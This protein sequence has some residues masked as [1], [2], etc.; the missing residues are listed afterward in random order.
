ME[1][2]T[3]REEAWTASKNK[4]NNVVVSD[5]NNLDI[6]NFNDDNSFV[7]V[8][9]ETEERVP[10]TEDEKQEIRK[11][12]GILLIIIVV[13]FILF[14]VMLI[15]D[16]FS[17]SNNSNKANE[18]KVQENKNPTSLYDYKDGEIK[19]TDKF[20]VKMFDEIKYNNYEAKDDVTYLYKNEKTDINYLPDNN[21][22]SLLAKTNAFK[23]KIKEIGTTEDICN[24][25][26]KV[27]LNDIFVILNSSFGINGITEYNKFNFVYYIDSY[28]TNIA[29][30]LK[31]GAYV[32]KCYK[33]ELSDINSYVEQKLTSVTK[34]NNNLYMDVKVLF[35]NKNGVY[36]DPTFKKTIPN[37]RNLTKDE[38]FEYAKTYR[39]S[40]ILSNNGYYLDEV[41]LVK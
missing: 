24:G 1:H 7:E 19:T 8:E 26:I 27:S 16:P 5:E 3:S 20:V 29:F 18:N 17:K 11:K 38:S 14:L 30:E 15:F 37:Y 12:L 22:L 10:L 36:Q 9:E 6:M 31:D 2:K 32:G 41:Y 23:E 13:V 33:V 28:I 4:K 34:D 40:Y 21:K 39:Y 25:E 35:I